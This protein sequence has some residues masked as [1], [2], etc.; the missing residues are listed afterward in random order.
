MPNEDILYV[1]HMLDT[2]EKAVAKVHEKSRKDF[3]GDENLYLSV[4]QNVVWKT[5]TEELEPL[6]AKLKKI[7]K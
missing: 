2:S 5:V 1:G 7:V 3:D 6:V 4:D